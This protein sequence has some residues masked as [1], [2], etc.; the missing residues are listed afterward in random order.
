MDRKS[1]LR[2]FGR[3]TKSFLVPNDSIV[4]TISRLKKVMDVEANVMVLMTGKNA[5]TAKASK[6]YN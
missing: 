6:C 1:H 5:H 3:H 4:G 2:E